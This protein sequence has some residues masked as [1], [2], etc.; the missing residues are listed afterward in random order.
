LH[1]S[2]WSIADFPFIFISSL[3]LST[4]FLPSHQNI[5][6]DTSVAQVVN[7]RTSDPEQNYFQDEYDGEGLNIDEVQQPPPPPSPFFPR[8]FRSCF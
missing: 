5:A 3:P 8:I 4:F 7:A 6:R 2:G 1:R